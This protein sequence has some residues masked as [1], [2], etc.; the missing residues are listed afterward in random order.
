MVRDL[1]FPVEIVVLPTVR[2]PDGL[3]MSSRN[4]YLDPAERERAASLRRALP[5]PRRRSAGAARGGAGAAARRA[6]SRPGIEPEYLEARDAERPRAGRR[7]STGGRCW[8][9][10][11]RGSAGPA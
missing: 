9:R 10:W 6:G 2:E 11:P 3:A 1:D 8:W 5:R 4:A 7:A